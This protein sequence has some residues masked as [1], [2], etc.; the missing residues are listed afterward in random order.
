MKGNLLLGTAAGKLGD[1]VFSRQNGQQQAR[2]RVTP[3]NPKSE[4][5]CRQRM[6][7][8]TISQAQS[9]LKTIIDH[10][11]EGVDTGMKSLN[12]FMK[13]NMPM[14]RAAA[15]YDGGEISSYN[16]F[17]IKGA[18]TLAVMPFQVAEGSLTYPAYKWNSYGVVIPSLDSSSLNVTVSNADQYRSLLATMG[19][20]PGDQLT[21]VAVTSNYEVAASYNEAVNR[22][23]HVEYARIIF[24]MP[25][26]ID[27]TSPF[28][29]LD[30]TS[31]LFASQI[32]NYERSSN[33]V[34]N[35]QFVVASGGGTLV[36][37]E[38]L[39]GEQFYMGALI[40]SARSDN[41]WLR[42]TAY[43]VGNI[44][45]FA[46]ADEVWPSYSNQ[47]SDLT[48]TRYLNQANNAPATA[49][50]DE[51]YAPSIEIDLTET[52]STIDISG[53]NMSIPEAGGTIVLETANIAAG[54]AVT[55]SPATAATASATVANNAISLTLSSTQAAALST[56]ETL[57]VTVRA[58]GASLTLG[59]KKKIA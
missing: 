18:K 20:A 59:L 4:A 12:Y 28:T 55:L 22:R 50:S 34:G 37:P 19:L 45:Y 38:I 44:D 54:S 41:S 29:F 47:T 15:A 7:F 9:M 42:S 39:S 33:W 23:S 13:L 51:A 53:F 58:G 27:F 1:I 49:I 11:F 32:I 40:R 43:L 26:Q 6:A 30:S 57:D 5:Q 25:N 21:L 35:I 46:T 31:G 8:A 48:S 10:S 52:S 16:D 3:K 17:L 14:V 56:T 2:P 24:Q 36:K